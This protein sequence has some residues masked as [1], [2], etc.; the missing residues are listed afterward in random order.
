MT[1]EFAYNIRKHNASVELYIDRG[2]AEENKSIFD[3][4][5]GSKDTI[6]AEFGEPLQWQRLEGKRAGSILKTSEIGG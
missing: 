2:D 5:Q 3:T 6:E 4:I 1:N